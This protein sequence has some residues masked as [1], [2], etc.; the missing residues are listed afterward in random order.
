MKDI[1]IWYTNDDGDRESM[2]MPGRWAICS[3]CD[4]HGKHVHPAIDGNGITSSEWAEWDD[5]EREMYFGGG[6]DVGCEEKCND[7]KQWVV[8]EE[9]LDNSQKAAYEIWCM[10]KDEEARERYAEMRMRAAES[11]W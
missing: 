6:Y 2:K 3:R 5:E 8:D 10:E 11:G 1:K 4:G 7:G 9:A